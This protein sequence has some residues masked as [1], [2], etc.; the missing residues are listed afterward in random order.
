MPLVSDPNHLTLTLA[1]S[2]LIPQGQDCVVYAVAV[3]G[4]V[5]TV[6]IAALTAIR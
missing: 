5:A 2:P 3:V 6:G 4:V 1:S